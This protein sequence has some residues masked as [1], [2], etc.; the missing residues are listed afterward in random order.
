MDY[1]SLANDSGAV[2]SVLSPKFCNLSRED[3]RRIAELAREQLQ[4]FFTRDR[5]NTWPKHSYDESSCMRDGY[6]RT[7]VT[8][9]AGGYFNL[10]ELLREQMPHCHCGSCH[11]F[12]S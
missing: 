5:D 7:L 4:E 3:R 8:L 9:E 1:Y 6:A 12:W 11:P 10:A 2:L